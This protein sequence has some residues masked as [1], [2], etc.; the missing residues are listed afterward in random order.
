MKVSESNRGS[1]FFMDFQN[2]KKHG[3]AVFFWSLQSERKPD[4]FGNMSNKTYFKVNC[5]TMGAVMLTGYYYTKPMGRGRHYS[6]DYPND[7]WRY[8]PQIHLLTQ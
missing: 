1:N 5:S 6:K 4:R 2:I 8:P 7:E 3:G